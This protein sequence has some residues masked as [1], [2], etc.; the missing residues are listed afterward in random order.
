V[1]YEPFT[2]VITEHVDLMIFIN[3]HQEKLH[4][5]EVEKRP[6]LL[7]AKEAKECCTLTMTARS[8]NLLGGFR[9]IA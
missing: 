8:R 3:Y 5:K 2:L 1:R 7:S 4:C 9:G 6:L